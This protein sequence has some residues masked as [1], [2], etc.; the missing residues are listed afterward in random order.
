MHGPHNLQP[1]P[2][3]AT[4]WANLV[5]L[6]VLAG[7]GL[8]ILV[9]YPYLGARGDLYGWYPL[10]GLAPPA[11]ATIGGWLA[12][13]RHWHFAFAWLLVAN[14]AVYVA[15]LVA[16]GEWRRRLFWPRRDARNAWGTLLHDLRLRRE[17]PAPV[18]LYNGMQRLAYTGVLAV[19]PLVV[20]SGLAMY[21]P[22]QLGV[23]AAL[24]GGYD[25][26][27]AVHLGGLAALA[28][29]TI[30]HVVQVLLHPRTLADMTVGRAERREEG[31]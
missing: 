29:F 24:L 25:A 21:K 19:A 3:R 20:V 4:H 8:R 7:S 30:V 17:P 2:I 9:A 10:Q 15:Y 26:A 31:G 28:L 16:S 22:V 27:R 11:A 6:V 18:G 13:A 14:A 1:W 23:L 5:L 12:G